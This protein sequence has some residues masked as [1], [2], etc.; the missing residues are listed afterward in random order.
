MMTKEILELVICYSQEVGS[1]PTDEEVKRIRE[2]AGMPTE[3]EI[4]E[5]T[6]LVDRIRRQPTP[7]LNWFQRVMSDT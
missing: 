2:L 3:E 4:Q 5:C 6:E 1:R 7:F